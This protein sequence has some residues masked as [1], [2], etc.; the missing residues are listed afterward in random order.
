MFLL[1]YI[2]KHLYRLLLHFLLPSCNNCNPTSVILILNVRRYFV[3]YILHFI[4]YLYILILKL[5]MKQSS[6]EHLGDHLYSVCTGLDR[7]TVELMSIYAGHWYS[8]RALSLSIL[9]CQTWRFYFF[10][11]VHALTVKEAKRHAHHPDHSGN[12]LCLLLKIGLKARA[13]S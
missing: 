13:V 11:S 6:M 8:A 10:T 4:I 2:S 3:K 1:L 5:V 9:G 7:D 12:L